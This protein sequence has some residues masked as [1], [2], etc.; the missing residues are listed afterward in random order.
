MISIDPTLIILMTEAMA[1]LV[2]IVIVLMVLMLKARRR[3]KAAMGELQGRLKKNAGL[4][5]EW[6]ESFLTEVCKYQGEGDTSADSMAKGWVQKENEFYSRVIDMYMQRN[7]SALRG[8]DKMMHEYTSS[9]L[10]LVALIRN[11]ADEE[12]ASL[13]EEAKQKLAALTQE[14]EALKADKEKIT[15]E[16]ETA[17][18]E[19]NL[20]MREYVTAFRPTASASHAT[21][22][23]SSE[24]AP[25]PA[26]APEPVLTDVPVVAQETADAIPLPDIVPVEDDIEGERAE[27]MQ[28]AVAAALVD[29]E[30]TRQLQDLLDVPAQGGTEE[31]TLGVADDVV[32]D[33]PVLDDVSFDTP[34]S[35]DK[36]KT[37]TKHAI[38]LSED[39]PGK[40]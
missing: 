40:A 37:G 28:T 10:E 29:E 15:Q 34:E 25:Q 26:V 27:V 36:T 21:S 9:Y 16:L 24:P 19:I 35:T 3:D 7:S 30:T 1:V 2:L 12:K 33:L 4:R 14:M 22:T 31:I 38:E 18:K 8:L 13:S 20:A 17:Q 5:H 23:P 39:P 11:R 32:V 6:F